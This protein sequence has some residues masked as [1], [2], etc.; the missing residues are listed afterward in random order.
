MDNVEA[1]KKLISLLDLTSLNDNDNNKTIEA[2]C[3]KA[4]TK[5]GNTASVC[6]YPQFIPY[7]KSILPEGFKIAT[8]IN[9]PN[10]IANNTILEREMLNAID[11]GAD[12]LDVVLPYR[13][14]LRML[15][16]LH[17]TVFP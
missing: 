10:G 11:L 9:F 14:F 15:C 8:V 3:Q 6:I 16:K 13:T 17:L 2:L 12:E 1:A 7:A 4:V 5:Y